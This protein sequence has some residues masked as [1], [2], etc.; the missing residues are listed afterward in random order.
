LDQD[1]QN[2]SILINRAPQVVNASIDL[3]KHFVEMPAF[4]WPR[5]SSAQIVSVGLTELEAPFSDGF[6]SEDHA[7]HRQHFFTIAEAQGEAKVQPNTMTDDF[8]R[9]AMTMIKR[10]GAHPCSMPH[11]LLDRLLDN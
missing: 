10:I 8:G 11:Q 4:A 9:E 2:I 1:V 6:M 7:T 5:S 3:E